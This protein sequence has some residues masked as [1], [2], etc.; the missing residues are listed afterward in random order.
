[1]KKRKPHKS[2]ISVYF[3][4]G[5]GLLLIVTAI[6]LVTQIAPATPTPTA[7]HAE[8]SYSEIQRV[9]LEDA[10][11][12]LDADTA[13]IVDIRATEAYDIGHIAGAGNI[14]FGELESHL[15]ELDK[16]QWIITYCT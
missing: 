7:S 2:Q 12:A 8:E 6:L 9:S 1:M 14:P 5:G 10:K 3:A 11:A 16:T 4:I 15:G 13:V